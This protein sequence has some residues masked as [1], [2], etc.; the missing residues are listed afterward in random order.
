M[1][2]GST[3][4]DEKRPSEQPNEP[5]EKAHMALLV[6]MAVLAIPYLSPNLTKYRVV[7]LPWETRAE[8]AIADGPTVQKGPEVGEAQLKASINEATITNALPAGSAVAPQI[9]P[10]VAAK[11]KG[12]LAV[13]DPTG[14]ALDAF[15]ASLKKTKSKE[16]GAVTRI[17]HY[18]DS[19]ITS[20]YI[21]GTLRRKMQTEYG[22]SG[23]GFILVANAW[24]WYF[25]N[26]V[27][28][29]ASEGWNANRITGPLT[30]DGMYGLGGVTFHG[31]PGATAAFGT[32]E[33]GD[34]GHKVS[35]FDIYYMEQPQGGDL[36]LKVDGK[37][38]K[39]VTRG[40]KKVSKVHSVEVPDGAATLNI[41]TVGNG[42]VRLFG[43]ALERNQ[44]GVT[45][46]A[47]GANGARIKLWEAMD[48][49]H[50]ADQMALRKP[51][52]VVMQFGTN[53]SEDSGLNTEFYEKSLRT[54]LEKLKAAAPN[55]SILVASPLDRAEKPEGGTFRT[56][57]VIPKIVASQKKV[58]LELGCAFWNTFEAMG[59]EGAMGKWVKA[60]PQLASWDL[61]HPTPAGAEVIG[62]MLFNALTTGFEAY[63][64]R[65]K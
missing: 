15:Y 50:W 11:L 22:D 24:E 62:E 51:A 30:R 4:S 60:N 3:V 36:E 61:T 48:G 17:L 44:P 46:D 12:S 55:A 6:M 40:E 33:K 13:E 43:V 54:V 5:F 41:R 27:T 47:L 19:V 21:S 56:R 18:G 34:Y 32:H 35:R 42:D 49:Q 9:D 16:P 52:L 26:D 7:R 23:H 39:L 29:R 64:G 8:E 59:G 1:V 31:A 25:H 37:V 57:K 10:Q 2:E 45:Y 53:E 65:T 14:H 63:Q 38:D 28:H 58:A 20:D